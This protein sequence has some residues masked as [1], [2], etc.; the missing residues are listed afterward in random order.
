MDKRESMVAGASQAFDADGFRGVGVDGILA[1]SGASTRTLYKHFGSRDGLVMAVLERRHREFM[2][3]LTAAGTGTDPI[4][5]LFDV[6]AH[7]LDDRGARGCMLLRARGEYASANPAIVA[8][9]RQHKHTF[10]QEIAQRVHA[11]L[12]RVDDELATQVW[13]LFEGATAA[14]SVSSAAVVGTARRAALALLA[15]AR[16]PYP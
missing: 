15:L 3:R 16:Q 13:L 8:L 7:W 11:A 12:G 1:H 9:V 10:E 5:E 2:D 6:L 4:S 14:A